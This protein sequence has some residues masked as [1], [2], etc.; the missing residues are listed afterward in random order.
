LKL[1]KARDIEIE[2]ASSAWRRRRD[3]YDEAT[4]LA[5]TLLREA[6]RAVRCVTEKEQPC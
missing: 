6:R 3:D 1:Q 5:E 4:K 2:A